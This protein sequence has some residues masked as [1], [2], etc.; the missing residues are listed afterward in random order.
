VKSPRLRLRRSRFQVL[1]TRPRVHTVGFYMH[2]CRCH[3]HLRR[4]HPNSYGFYA[5]PYAM[6][7]PS[8]G[9]MWPQVLGI[10]RL[11]LV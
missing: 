7:A 10:G 1:R 8:K 11:S 4:L 6:Q 5:V 9:G 2:S 3:M